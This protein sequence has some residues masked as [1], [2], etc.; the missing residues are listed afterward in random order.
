MNKNLYIYKI[1]DRLYRIV[2]KERGTNKDVWISFGKIVPAD[3]PCNIL[4]PTE[5]M[6]VE[7]EIF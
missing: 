4:T 7:M 5:E 2:N 1:S 3:N 6:A